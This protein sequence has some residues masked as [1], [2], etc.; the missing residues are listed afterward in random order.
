MITGE[1]KPVAKEAGD[2][3]VGGTVNGD[4]SL[5]VEVRAVGDETALAG[6]MKLVEEAQSGKSR[7]QML[8]DRAAGALFYVALGVAVLSAIGWWFV[9]GWDISI[10]RRIATVLVIAC[11]HALGLAVPLVLANTTAMGAA[12]GILVRDRHALEQARRL[13]TIVFDKTGT[14]TEGEQSLAEAR[15]TEGIERDRALAIAAAV[16][17]D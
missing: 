2:E 16:E 12:A 14:L 7:G 15:G 10:L 1:S 13:D 11:P 5:R 8:A 9:L 6:I 4:G 17:G 3:V